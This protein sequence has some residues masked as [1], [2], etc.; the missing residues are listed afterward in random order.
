MILRQKHIILGTA[1][2]LGAM[3]LIVHGSALKGE[4]RADDPW[5]ILYVTEHPEAWRYFFSPGQWQSLGVPF[6]TPWLTLEYWL[7]FHLFGFKPVGFYAHHLIS[8]WCAAVLT[9]ILLYRRV[10]VFGAGA[11]A[12]FF[13]AG[14]PVVVVSQQLMSRH[15]VTGLVFTLLA[16]LFYLRARER[17]SRPSLALAAVC[18]LVAMLNKE[19]FAP[20]PLVLFFLD[21]ATYKER[22]YAIA[23]FGFV[24][25][26]YIFWR[27]VMLGAIIGG[28]GGNRLHEARNI[29]ASIH[30]LLEVIWGAN[31]VLAGSMVLLLVIGLQVVREPRM[32]PLLAPSL[33]ALLLPL[34]AIRITPNVFDFRLGLLPWW[35]ICVMLSWVYVGFGNRLLWKICCFSFLGVIIGMHTFS[36][37]KSYKEI[38]DAYDVQGNFLRSHPQ[39]HGYIPSGNVRSDISFQYATSAL[40][41]AVGGGAPVAVPFVESRD[42]LGSPSPI[43]YYENSCG[44]MEIMENEKDIVGSPQRT[45]VAPLLQ[46]VFFDRTKDGLIW[47]FS[48]PK[49][50]SCFLLFPLLNISAQI[51]CN[52]QIFF[53]PPSWLQG[54]LRVLTHTNAGQWDSSPI[55]KFPG[56]GGQVQWH[57]DSSV[58]SVPQAIQQQY[59]H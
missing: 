35:G 59:D 46:A 36:T 6:F 21:K 53:N 55:L 18:Y 2:L 27:S 16:I 33:V 38:A 19:I 20:L 12:L 50:S 9:F 31:L 14:S 54:E 10:G 28:Y 23:P 57:K 56:K 29:I 52:G 4:W 58:G 8:L 30:A 24:A 45:A 42:L 41:S 44:C 13:L 22:L 43:L 11:A 39:R 49:N 15:Y 47:E 48:V 25:G 37:Q 34:L 17:E 51:P 7:D 26:G 5:I 32:R 1:V 40:R 3:T